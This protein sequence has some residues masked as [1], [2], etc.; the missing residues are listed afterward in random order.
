MGNLLSYLY[1]I[2]AALAAIILHELA[3]AL[4]STWLGDPTPKETGRLS[5]NPM[6]HLDLFG[7]VALILFH[8][9]WAKPVRIDTRYYK[10]PRLGLA[11]VSIAGPLTNFILAF[12]GGLFVI[13]FYYII[14]VE[15]LTVIFGEF[16]LYFVIINVGL[17]LFNLIP[18]PPLDGSKI[19]GSMLPETAYYQYMKYERYGMFFLLIV[20]LLI[21]ILS[22]TGLPN[23]ISYV[24]E[25]IYIFILELWGR[26]FGIA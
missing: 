25:H 21:N 3:H 18:I 5:L 19:I 11:L 20:I 4:V 15:V 16:F 12:I 14:N 17:G 13:L 2:P 8:V 23:I 7:I 24:I 6:K 9:G 22:Y 1:I 26:I 10:H